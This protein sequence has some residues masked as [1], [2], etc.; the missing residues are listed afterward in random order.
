[1]FYVWEEKLCR[2]K[3]ALKGWAKRQS[4]P[5]A[6]CLEAQR[7][8]ESHQ[9]DLEKRE[10]TQQDLLKEDQLQ[11]QW[12]KACRD[13]EGYWRQKSRSL[14]LKEGDKNT[15]YFHK[16]AEARK[17]YKAVTEIQVQNITISD[18]E[19]IRQASFETF[20][21]L[22]SETQKEIIDPQRYPLSI[23]PNLIKDD[24]NLKLV[25]EVTQQEIK[26][27]L[28]QMHPDKALGPDGFTARFYQ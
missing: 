14:W 25:E 11:R 20:R 7:R 8:L 9:L 17:H 16:Q 23:V 26:E 15:S 28:D 5:I 3:V 19:G 10:I 18:P 22:Y 6:L 4:D 24:I 2:L 1:V 21:T 12:H 13:E 27:A